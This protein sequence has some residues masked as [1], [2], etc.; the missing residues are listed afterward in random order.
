MSRF[1]NAFFSKISKVSKLNEFYFRRIVSWVAIVDRHI[2]TDD[3]DKCVVM[4]DIDYK[5]DI[6]RPSSDP[7]YH[8]GNHHT[9]TIVQY[10]DSPK[11]S[12]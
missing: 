4:E 11:E 6:P 8:P 9:V 10:D 7:D 12:S 1:S 2:Q 3:F 5:D